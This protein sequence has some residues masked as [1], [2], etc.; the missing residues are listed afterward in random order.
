[1]KN[2]GFLAT[3]LLALLLVSCK[4]QSQLPEIYEGPPPPPT[5]DLT[6][7]EQRNLDTLFVSAPRTVEK[8]ATE[9]ETAPESYDLPIYRA[10]HTRINDLQ[11][12][13]LD[14]RFDWAN[15]KVIGEAWL[16]LKPFFY[17]TDSLTLDAKDF[18]IKSITL[19]KDKKKLD[20]E[21]DAQKIRIQLD[22]TYNR[23]ESYMIHI[24]YE[25][26]PS[27]SGGSEAI[28]SN[29]GLFFINAD[30]EIPN[31]PQQ[32]WTQ[33]ETNWNSRWFPTIDHPN[34]RTSQEIILTVEDRF[35][36]LS[37]GLRISSRKNSDGTRTDHWKMEKE[38]APYLF[39]LAVGEFAVVE[40]Q[41]RDMPL[42]YY[43]E[44][45]Y[46]ASAK[47]IFSNTP[48]M[49]EF[50]SNKLDYP[51][52]W[53]KYAQIVVRDYVSGAMENTSAVV[54][55]D[56]VQ[57]TKEELIDNHNEDIV[58][59]EMFHHWF[60]DLVTCESWAN[61][62]MNEGFATY[63][64]YLWFEHQYGAD[65]ADYHLL[66]DWN[67]Y[68]GEASMNV[69][70]LI[71]FQY[72]KNEDMFDRHSYQKGGS[73]LHM[74]RNYIGDEAFWAG[75][76]HYLKTHEYSAVE[77]HDLRLSFEE[78][79]GQDLNWFFNQWYFEKGHPNLDVQYGYDEEAKEVTVTVKQI[80]DPKEMLPVFQLPVAIDIYD[81]KGIPTR[82][83]AWIDAREQEFRFPSAAKPALVNFDG[84]RVLLAEREENKTE[85]EF[86]FQFQYAKKFMDR[87]EA[88]LSIAQSESPLVEQVLSIALDDPHWVI[89]AIAVDY[90][91]METADATLNDRLKAIAVDDPHSQVRALALEKLFEAA[92]PEMAQTAEAILKRDSATYV[93]GMALQ[94][95]AEADPQKALPFAEKMQEN[96]GNN[97]KP[98]VGSVYA[99]NADQKY[100]PFFKDNIAQLDGPNAIAFATSYQQLAVELDL[101]A[102]KDAAAW[103][104][105]T[106]MNLDDS[107]WRRAAS[108]K[109]LADMRNGLLEKA[110]SIK[111]LMMQEA[112]QT[113][114]EAIEKQVR[115]VIDNET[116]PQLKE[117]Y[118]Q[119]EF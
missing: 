95:L 74:L 69:H 34:E 94:I 21:Y 73:I 84:D 28:T 96:A 13:K 119:L 55:G 89:R 114:A 62:T 70:P 33:G 38:H 65:E 1:M 76:N 54:F 19:G 110:T 107:L 24:V 78:V 9:A 64:E 104:E 42:Y 100:L 92:P 50:F 37:N 25:A 87:Y 11:H 22:K 36:T 6:E 4:T 47:G 53:D 58:A 10:S 63:S 117:L 88:L 97:L 101:E 71:H 77:S 91:N 118:K 23:D 67:N 29:Q 12:T 51:F 43:V 103:F 109:A 31:K 52:P 41:W 20:F 3:F 32:I 113:Q 61:L 80:Q 2:I 49:L 99:A 68:F 27:A 14:L 26:V 56:F 82:H 57:K 18:D 83:E 17:P 85:E 15:E 105:K 72:N 5:N 112:Y 7:V 75:L 115:R 59:H 102:V 60:G 30:G 40:D 79:T 66:N 86:L 45:D 108:A 46:E 81:E 116:D 90:Q 39:M 111:E 35:Q 106:G 93:L 8:T 48:E 98:V 44:P 16:T